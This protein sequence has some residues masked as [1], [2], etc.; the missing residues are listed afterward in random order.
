MMFWPLHDLKNQK[1]FFEFT[2]LLKIKGAKN[3]QQKINIDDL[4]FIPL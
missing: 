3:Q 2:L 1:C 4:L